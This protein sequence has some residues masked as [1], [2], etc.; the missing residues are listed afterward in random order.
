M[1]SCRA[2]ADKRAESMAITYARLLGA[3]IKSL[4]TASNATGLIK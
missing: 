3:L 4:P 2:M 1:V